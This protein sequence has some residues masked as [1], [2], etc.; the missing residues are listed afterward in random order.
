MRV[1]RAITEEEAASLFVSLNFVKAKDDWPRILESLKEPWVPDIQFVN[2]A[3]PPLVLAL[4]KIA[5]GLRTAKNLLSRDQADRL[6]NLVI[7]TLMRE[8]ML[9]IATK[10]TEELGNELNFCLDSGLGPDAIFQLGNVLYR[11]MGMKTPSGPDYYVN[12]LLGSYLLDAG[13][14]WKN[15][16]DQCE[17]GISEKSLL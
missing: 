12:S 4:A 3:T 5:L 1:R 15:I 10:G 6:C 13:L 14:A 2:P 9:D 11:Y 8:D 7:E 16:L 17:I